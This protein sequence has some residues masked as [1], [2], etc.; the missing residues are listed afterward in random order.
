MEQQ[1]ASV[2]ET[3]VKYDHGD[4]KRI[5]HFVKVHNF[6]ATIGTSE[7]MD[8]PTLFVLETAAILHDIGIHAA[9]LKYGNCNGKAQEELGPSEAHRLLTEVGGYTQAQIERICW[10][11]A[12]HH[13][14]SPIESID[15]RILIEADFLVNAYEDHLSP[16]AIRTFRDK[17]FRTATA[18]RLLNSMFDLH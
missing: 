6:A 11:I 8:A 18:I 1:L 12:H 3:M 9:E 4:A 10:L 13:T 16:D 5:Q 15:H 14:Y 17:V 7:G 2:M